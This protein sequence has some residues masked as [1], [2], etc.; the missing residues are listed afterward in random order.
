MS[1]CNRVEVHY[2][3]IDAATQSQNEGVYEVDDLQISPEDDNVVICSWLI[4]Q[5]AT[6]FIG[7]IHFVVRFVCT[8]DSKIDYAWNTAIFSG[9]SVSTGMYHSE[10]VIEDYPDV[11][12]QW[13]DR[14][15]SVGVNGVIDARNQALDDI[16]TATIEKVELLVKTGGTIVSENE[17]EGEHIDLW[18]NPSTEGED[19]I[20]LEASDIV[21]ELSND[22]D[23]V[24]S[25]AVVNKLAIDLAEKQTATDMEKITYYGD[26][27]I[28]ISD[29]NLFTF[30]ELDDG[31]YS[32]KAKDIW[33]LSG[34][35]V[36]PYK[37]NGKF[38][39]EITTGGFASHNDDSHVTLI[40]GLT[41]PRT[42]RVIN[43]TAFARNDIPEVVIPGSCK[44]IGKTAFYQ[45]KMKRLVLEEGV[46]EIG[47]NA[48]T[49]CN[50]VTYCVIPSTIDMIYINS[51]AGAG[52]VKDIY[53]GGSQ[54]EFEHKNV[55]ELTI[56]REPLKVWLKDWIWQANIYYNYGNN[57]EVEK[58]VESN[59]IALDAIKT[60]MS[61]GM[62]VKEKILYNG[63]KYYIHPNSFYAAFPPTKNLALYYGDGRTDDPYQSYKIGLIV[64]IN[65]EVQSD[66]KF[67]SGTIIQYDGSIL[68]ANTTAIYAYFQDN[69]NEVDGE[70]GAYLQWN[71]GNNTYCPIL[72]MERIAEV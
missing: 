52:Q 72:H 9:I 1:T 62:T 6:K 7:S 20:L 37:Y 3:N 28:E 24:P 43:S 11:L 57:K 22:T 40:T 63:Q 66:G 61:Q 32:I 67:R 46:E 4:S 10:S 13:Y 5:N 71:G 58:A 38:V 54:Y 27:N 60:A 69:T 18:V 51:F 21:Q 36:L 14:L 26:I 56:G 8:T 42:I 49:A 39:T 29:E 41:I 65:S 23:K 59:T 19:V 31:T 17:P 2:I 68:S 55:G 15:I 12:Q 30:T 48:F 70:V 33:S 16:E 64:G 50:Q 53:Y 44:K 45:S 47:A 34:H 25:V 35:I